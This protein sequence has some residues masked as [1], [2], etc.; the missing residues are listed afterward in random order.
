MTED[1]SARKHL[2]VVSSVWPHVEGSFEAANVVAHS[3]V[4]E[5]AAAGE[6]DL[7]YAYVNTNLVQVP[8]QA[9]SE[10]AS[11]RA[12]GVN[13]LEPLLLPQPPSWRYRPLAFAK[14]LLARPESFLFGYDAGRALRACRHVRATLSRMRRLNKRPYTPMLSIIFIHGGARIGVVGVIILKNIIVRTATIYLL[15]N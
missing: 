3:I 5:I 6:F 8:L 4:A 14:A 1:R 10:L 13:F 9:E 15:C 12:A 2:L 11:L 7:S